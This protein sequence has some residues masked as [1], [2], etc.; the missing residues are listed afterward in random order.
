VCRG[1][2]AG[3][4][5]DASALA[6]PHTHTHTLSH[7]AL[8]YIMY[9]HAGL[10]LASGGAGGGVSPKH[11]E[12][13]SKGA[14]CAYR[15]CVCLSR[16]LR[17]MCKLTRS[18]FFLRVNKKV[19]ISPSRSMADDWETTP[20]ENLKIV[21]PAPCC[22]ASCPEVLTGLVVCRT[23]QAQAP[24]LRRL[25]RRRRSLKKPG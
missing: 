12:A 15:P 25:Q 23:T 22:R 2:S 19:G 9:V 5:T 6:Q 20:L 24:E 21:S 4:R 17:R 11:N 3:S 7:T 16:V 13:H 10:W 18:T 14:S 8:T 1:W